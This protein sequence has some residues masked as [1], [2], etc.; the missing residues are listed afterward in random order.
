MSG[1]RLHPRA[2]GGS[3]QGTIRVCRHVRVDQERS[4][5]GLAV[6]SDVGLPVGEKLTLFLVGAAG[7]L[8]LRVKVLAVQP[9]IIDGA[10][11]HRLR[12]SILSVA[13]ATNEDAC[14]HRLRR[15]IRSN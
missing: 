14:A 15:Q 12:L 1:R 2:Q 5:A 8:E 11:L 13:P 3:A 10:V 9:R 4:G 7:R 6:L